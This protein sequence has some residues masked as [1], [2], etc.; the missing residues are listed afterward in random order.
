MADYLISVQAYQKVK[1]ALQVYLDSDAVLRETALG[2]YI[3]P[4]QLTNPAGMAIPLYK[5]ISLQEYLG[6]QS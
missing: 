2:L 1:D 6:S 5:N 4:A 3:E